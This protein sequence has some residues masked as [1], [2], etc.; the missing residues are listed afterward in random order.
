[1]RQ[2]GL[3]DYDFVFESECLK[4]IEK[5]KTDKGIYNEIVDNGIYET[6]YTYKSDRFQKALK[7]YEDY[8]PYLKPEF[9]QFQIIQDNTYKLKNN[10]TVEELFKFIKN[11][12][13]NI[14]ND[15]FKRIN[16]LHFYQGF[17]E[18]YIG[19]IASINFTDFK[20]EGGNYYYDLSIGPKLEFPYNLSVWR[21]E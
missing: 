11:L 5:A 9:K 18:D 19:R 8:V 4:L 16:A 10:K 13:E 2:D 6:L 15:I 14:P 7:E 3:T 17:Y 1:M 21:T 12:P 20:K